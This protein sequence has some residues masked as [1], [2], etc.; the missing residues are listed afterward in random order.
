MEITNISAQL[1]NKQLKPDELASYYGCKDD[2]LTTH[3]TTCVND[4]ESDAQIENAFQK[5]LDLS[6]YYK[7]RSVYDEIKKDFMDKVMEN[8]NHPPGFSAPELVNRV[9][10]PAVTSEAVPH[11]EAGPRD[12]LK[13]SIKSKEFFGKKNDKSILHLIIAAVAIFLI[14]FFLLTVFKRT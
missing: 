5:Q 6:D 4:V 8:D 9:R 2:I 14:V 7:G 1:Y 13:Q 10:Q 11:I 3:L 12:K